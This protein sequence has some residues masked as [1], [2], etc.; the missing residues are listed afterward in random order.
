MAKSLVIVESPAKAKTIE[1]FLGKDFKVAASMGHVRDLPRSKLSVDLEN[2]FQ[3]TYVVMKDRKKIITNLKDLIKKVQNVYLAPDPD[4]EG[5]AIAWHLAQV[6]DV[7]DKAQRIEFNEITKKAVQDALLHS[8]NIDMHRVE[9]QQARRILD[10]IV[11]Y[12]ISP[13]LWK[14]I[15]KGLSAGR[16]QSVAVRLICEREAEINAFK[17]QEYW[18]INALLE[19]AGREKF[20]AELRGL[21]ADKK[22]K[23]KIVN[24]DEAAQITSE[25]NSAQYIVDSVERKEQKRHPAAPFITST[26]QQEAAR[27][28]GFTAKKT[29]AVAQQLYE[30]VDL[31]GEQVGLITYMR[32]DSVR[33]SDEALAVTRQFIQAEYGLENLA[34]TVR[35]YK[36]KKSAQ[37]AHEAVRP[38]LVDHTPEKVQASLSSDQFELYE[39]IWKRFVACQMAS[40]V[41]DMTAIDIAAGRYFFRATGSVLKFAGF[42]KLYIEGKD[43]KEKD[44]GE[45]EDSDKDRLLPDLKQQEVLGLSEL[46]SEQHFTQP[47]PRYTEASLVKMLEEKGIGRPSTYASIMSAIQDRGYVQRDKKALLPTE[48]GITVNEQLIKHFPIIL[49][50]EFTA[51]LEDQLDSIMDGN[52]KWQ[53]VLREFYDPFAESLAKAVTDMETLKPPDRPTEE[54]CEKCSK[55]MVIKKGRF[56]EFMACTGFPECRNTKQIKTEPKK[57]GVICPE[58][59]QELIERKTRKGKYFY[60]CLGYP[61]CKFALWDKPTGEKCPQ[62]SALLVE[63]RKNI[64]CTKCEYKK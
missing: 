32:T 60:G 31:G 11:G 29:M 3:P 1:K 8:R 16:V 41:M 30:G 13:L 40:A 5:E 12:K 4:R 64:K 39:L 27:K 14:K 35:I 7:E 33:I 28:L 59:G 63:S 24:K 23:I 49:D 17:E 15:Q 57:I 37:D 21:L 26:L 53:D 51:R 54:I 36:M 61:T 62:C 20:Q 52:I 22:Q 56:G 55:P 18:T 58:C 19:T 50:I 48:M 43:Q 10:R 42:M 47:P 38:T 9:A 46:K 44:D 34:P 25:L 45:S 6:L 2:N